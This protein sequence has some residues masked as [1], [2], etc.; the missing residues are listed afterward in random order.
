VLRPRAVVVA[1]VGSPAT[2][3]TD[4]T[5]GGRIID[6]CNLGRF[7][8]LLPNPRITPLRLSSRIPSSLKAMDIHSCRIHLKPMRMGLERMLSTIL[9]PLSVR[10]MVTRVALTS[11]MRSMMVATTVAG[12]ARARQATSG[13]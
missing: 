3:P 9:R 11:I 13:R 7:L 1:A 8:E 12:M 6:Q 10:I 2:Q 4:I 5:I